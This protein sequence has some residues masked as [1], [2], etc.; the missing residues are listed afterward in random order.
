MSVHFSSV[1]LR[2]F[3]RIFIELHLL[4]F[5]IYLLFLQQVREKIKSLHSSLQHFELV[6][7][8]VRALDL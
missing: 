2:F 6:D 5:I 1:Q 7:V 4:Q 3:V 8:T